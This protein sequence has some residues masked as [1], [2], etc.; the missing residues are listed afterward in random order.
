MRGAAL[1]ILI[2]LAFMQISFAIPSENHRYGFNNTSNDGS[3][4]INLNSIGSPIFIQGGLA[5]GSHY[6]DCDGNDAFYTSSFPTNFTKISFSWIMN[7]SSAKLQQPEFWHIFALDAITSGH[8]FWFSLGTDISWGNAI[9]FSG[10]NQNAGIQWISSNLND[11]IFNVTTLVSVSISEN[12]PIHIYVNGNEI[13]MILSPNFGTFA[14]RT[15]D[16]SICSKM[17]DAGASFLT[18]FWEGGTDDF[19]IWFDNLS[20]QDWTALYQS[21]F[22]S[23]S[24]DVNPPIISEYNVTTDGGCL[25]WNSNKNNACPTSSLLP[26]IQFTTNENAWCAIGGSRNNGSLNLNY[27]GLGNGRNCSFTSSGEGTNNHKCSL[28]S[29][30]EM[31]YEDSYL[32]I[33][34]KDSN[35]NQNLNST[36]GPLRINS[37]SIESGA[38]NAI[39]AAIQNSLINSYTNFSNQLIAVRSLTNLQ[40]QG[41]FDLAAKKGNKTWAF[42]RIGRGE[43]NIKMFNLTPVLY[44]LEFANVSTSNIART[45]EK[46]INA[47]R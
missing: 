24:S 11:T 33:S 35:G 31:V 15:G 27:T 17:G 36:S 2:F 25:S 41:I 44:T 3:G 22:A 9:R 12:Q 37:N 23:S 45:V 16:M 46:F 28:A 1:F 7:A 5:E 38:E 10:E 4:S 42:S 47:T 18:G 19:R 32:F 39:R 13:P 43:S 30:D 6:V 29:L 14:Q 26:T 20:K 8:N 40:A 34:C 21:Y